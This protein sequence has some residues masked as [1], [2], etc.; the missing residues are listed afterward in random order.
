MIKSDH[1]DQLVLSIGEERAVHLSKQELAAG[2]ADIQQSPKDAGQLELIVCRPKVGERREL[3][4]GELDLKWGLIGDNWL[5]RGYRKT[6]NGAAHPDMQ[7]NIMNARAIALIAGERER[8][9][10]AGDQFYVDLD[11]SDS[12]L[13][14]GTRLQFGDA[15]LQI[16]AE[17][18]LGCRK[19]MDR[20]G[21]DAAQFV[22]SD[23]GKAL[24]LRGVNAKVVQAGKVGV[25]TLIRKLR[26]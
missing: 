16:T 10:L 4:Q 2:L 22:N 20:F 3:E 7:I 25:G 15:I 12:N 23:I 26:A 13:P 19:F 1:S 14:V 9:K 24:N 6:I 21:R 17:P 18:H 8:W 11:L 5:A